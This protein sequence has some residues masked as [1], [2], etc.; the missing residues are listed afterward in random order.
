MPTSTEPRAS[1]SGYVP[2]FSSQTTKAIYINASRI[3]LSTNE[4]VELA[5]SKSILG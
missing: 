1:A 4:G 5:P 2:G 3:A